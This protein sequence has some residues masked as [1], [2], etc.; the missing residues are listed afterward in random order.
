MLQIFIF[1]ASMFVSSHRGFG[2]LFFF[3][4]KVDAAPDVIPAKAEKKD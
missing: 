2:S 3:F 4:F 1:T